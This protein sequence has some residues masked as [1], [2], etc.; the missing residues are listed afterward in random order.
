MAVQT[1]ISNTVFAHEVDNMVLV[2]IDE[3]Q[4]GGSAAGYCFQDPEELEAL[5]TVLARAH[6]HMTCGNHPP[7]E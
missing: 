1:I 3:T 6:H 4:G 2:N 7:H 5:V